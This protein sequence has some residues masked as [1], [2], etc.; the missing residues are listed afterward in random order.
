VQSRPWWR[1]LRRTLYVIL[2]LL[3]ALAGVAYFTLRSSL[4][5]L[6]GELRSADLAATTTIERDAL[7]VPTIRGANRSDVAWATGFVHAQ[8]RFFQMDLSRRLAAGELS[9]IIGPLALD[10]DRRMRI[11]RFRDVAR[12]VLANA[13]AEDRAIAESYAR[14]VNA[15]RAALDG[16]PFEYWLLQSAPTEWRAEDSILVVFA[17]YEQLNYDGFATESARGRVHEAVPESL[18][19]FIYARGGEWDA[20]L[21]GP[22]FAIEPPPTAAEFSLRSQ[23]LPLE[24]LTADLRHREDRV[25]GSNNWA[26]AGTHTATGAALLADDMHL[27]LSVPNTWYRARLQVAPDANQGPIEVT[28]VTLPGVPLMVVGSNG[29][30]AWGF[31]NSQ[32]DWVDLIVLQED[33][34]EP[35]RYATPEGPKSF[36]TVREV[37]HVRGA[38][39]ETL[40]VLETIW[41]PVFDRDHAGR[42]RA[43]AWIAHEPRATNFALRQLETAPDVAAALDIAARCGAP[44]QNFVAADAQGNIGWTIMGSI[45]VRHG[46]DSRVPSDWSQP[47]TGWQGWLAPDLYPRIINPPQG[48]IWTANARVVEGEAL[49]RLGESDLYLGARAQQIRDDLLPL[50]SATAADMLAIQLDDRARFLERWHLKLEGLL[51]E[52][53]VKD[54]PQRAGF[55]RLLQPWSGR[56]SV[57][58]VAY[59]LVR[60]WRRTMHDL[61]FGALTYQARSANEPPDAIEVPSQFEGPL[62]ELMSTEPEHLL[63]ANFKSWRE[64]ELNAVDVT[65]ATLAKDCRALATCTWGDRNR[66][67]IRHPLGGLPLLGALLNMTQN[68]LPG[69][70]HMPRVQAVSFGASER[71]AVSPGHEAQGYFHMPGGQSG[72]PLSPFY[73]AGHDAWAEGRPLPFL[74]GATAHRLTFI[75]ASE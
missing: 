55:R 40:E 45:P 30:V 59:R 18:Y 51:D 48:K 69:D 29:R 17:M 6:D 41:G 1:A 35:G 26:V 53:A 64:L 19:R 20:P 72:H 70:S 23:T 13:S 74:P 47:G 37:I 54:A 24:R 14:G 21:V 32:G 31:T 3:L 42:R 38:S 36:E 66:V 43:A 7:G 73:R 56:A 10:T 46:Y 12:R 57:E 49:Q 25:F 28:G 27:G 2:I 16:R 34:A 62:W 22:A 71:L 44:P 75:R 8:E 68:E 39:D 50:E 58:S 65:I 15:G 67:R 52:A 11:H 9:E 60:A 33:P 5:Q 4:P 61:V 63:P